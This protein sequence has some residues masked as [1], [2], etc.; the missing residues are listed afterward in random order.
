MS[1]ETDVTYPDDPSFSDH[2][3]YLKEDQSKEPEALRLRRFANDYHVL[4]WTEKCAI[5]GR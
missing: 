5:F 4:K 2:A 1:L 3:K